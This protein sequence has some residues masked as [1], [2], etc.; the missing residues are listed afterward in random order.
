MSKTTAMDARRDREEWPNRRFGHSRGE[1]GR[2]AK[3]ED[4]KK[5]GYF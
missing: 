2:R 4:R 3:R 1:E 5:Q